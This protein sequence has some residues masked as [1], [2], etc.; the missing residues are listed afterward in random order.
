MN[1]IFHQT[2]PVI[3]LKFMPRE[4][5]EFL[6]CN[7][8]SIEQLQIDCDLPDIVDKDNLT[9]DA[10]IHH[11]HSYKLELREDGQLHWKDG[12]CLERLKGLCADVHDFN[13]EGK[14]DMVRYCLGK[15]THYII[16]GSGGTSPHNFRGKPWSLYHEKFETELGFFIKKNKTDIEKIDFKFNEFKDIYKSCRESAINRWNL[17]RDIVNK[18]ENKIQLTDAEQ[19]EI[20]EFCIHQVGNIWTT[21]GKELKIIK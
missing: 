1:K 15:M 7:T 21:L 4:F 17:G 9:Q 6:I 8:Y 20:C 10:E 2:A 11:A 14:L 5:Q 12:D 19:I 3:A 13:A 18:Y 16:D